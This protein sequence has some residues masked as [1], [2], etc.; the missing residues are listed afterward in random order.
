[1]FAVA[2]LGVAVGAFGP[3]Y[4]HSAD[5]SVLDGVLA[6]TPPA[7]E[8]LTLQAASG[9]GTPEQLTAAVPSIPRPASGRRWFGRPIETEEVG[10]TTVTQGQEY[11]SDLVARSGVCAHLSI[12]EGRCSGNPGSVIMSTRSANE[13]GARLGQVLVA[14]VG[15]SRRSVVLTVVGLYQAGSAQ[16]PY[17]WG[18]NYFPFGA[19]SPRVP[20][21]DDVFAAPSTVVDSSNQVFHQIQL[22]FEQGSLV[23]GDTADLA[24]SLAAYHASVLRAHDVVSSTQLTV[25]IGTADTSEHTTATIVAV[26]DLQLV[27]L[28]LFALYFVS[29]RTAAERLPDLRLAELRGYRQRSTFAVALAEP[30]A[31]VLVSVPLGLVLAW[32]VTRLLAPHLF[33]PGIGTSMTVLA[34]GAACLTGIVGVATVAVG[35]RRLAG[36]AGM[37]FTDSAGASSSSAWRL[38]ADAAV[39]ATAL[40]AFVEL[41]IAGVTSGATVSPTNPLAALAP[42][43]LALGVS[44]LGARLLPVV[45]RR[46]FRYTAHSPKVAMALASRRVA[47]NPEFV[48]QIVLVAIAASLAT[49][50]VTGWA[51]AS[52]NRAIRSEF[53]VGAPRVLVVAVRRGVD[54]LSATRAADGGRHSAMAAVVE[55]APDGT[56]LAVDSSSLPQVA[57]WPSG[58]NPGGAREVARRLVGGRLAPPVLISGTALE[59]TADARI[60]AQPPPD[61]AVDLFD[62]GFQTSQQVVFGPLVSGTATYRTPLAGLCP[63][64]CRLVDLAVTWSPS[65]STTS[66]VGTA[67]LVVSAMSSRSSTG[68]WVPLA[69]GLHDT[70]RWTSPSHGT[71][72]GASPQGLSVLMRLSAFAPTTIAPADVPDTLPTVLTTLSASL[73]SGV[74]EAIPLVGLDGTTVNGRLV[75]QVPVL[76]RLG[77]AGSLVDLGLAERMMSG[78]MI[79]VTTEV[80]LGANAPGTIESS[81]AARGV[82]VVSVETAQL[83]DRSLSHSGTSL[84]YT[85]FLLAAIAAAALAVGATGFAVAVTAR[86]RRT[87]FATMRALGIAAS[88]LRR[89]V[90]IEQAL[91][92]GTGVVLGAAAGMVSAVVALKSVPEFVGLGPG[93]PLNF[94]LPFVPLVTI[95]GALILTLALA[96]RVVASQELN[97]RSL[98]LLGGK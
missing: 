39:V 15:S 20:E 78:P 41:T 3:L 27:L 96:V 36:A 55:S 68:R 34:V 71:Q 66:Q 58:L 31:I 10:F 6:A 44:V 45:L 43:L 5:Q 7:N 91:A 1:M 35:A 89:S 8:G 14:S 54:L 24:A 93:P 29:L 60:D 49:F 98:D 70:A 83:R 86:R 73:G 59:I 17:W 94:G 19:G 21:I 48:A 63:G 18:A 64:G 12:L 11:V 37:G 53:N 97:H 51:T 52:T 22:P 74:G 32:L 50:G 84:A 28:A 88:S 72:I 76:P 81:L 87:E 62:V 23:N 13:M 38:A 25:L 42:G 4:L 69:A 9:N 92:L 47:R 61:L 16:D 67:D 56:T 82:S 40:A 75:E 90:E 77:D 79:N 65:D 2:V 95:L 33:L 85:L 80:W 46:T 57:S 30:C 26:V